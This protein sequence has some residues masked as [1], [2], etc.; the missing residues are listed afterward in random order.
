MSQNY[1]EFIFL[2]CP[3][4]ERD[5]CDN[6]TYIPAEVGGKVYGAISSA[7]AKNL[8]QEI[9][10]NMSDETKAIFNYE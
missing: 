6:C 5:K 4:K 9:R 3:C 7:I 8:K 1:K 2:N 10:E